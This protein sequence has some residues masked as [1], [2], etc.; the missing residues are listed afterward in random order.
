MFT[1]GRFYFALFLVHVVSF[2]PDV[3]VKYLKRQLYHVDWQVVLE[4]QIK[5]KK[6]QAETDQSLID[7]DKGTNYGGV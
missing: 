1:D 2:L 3:C 5:K 4:S 6:S 7:T